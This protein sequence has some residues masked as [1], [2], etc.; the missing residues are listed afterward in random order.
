VRESKG[1]RREQRTLTP[2]WC[3]L[4]WV[5]ASEGRERKKLSSVLRQQIGKGPS[6]AFENLAEISG[7]IPMPNL[8]RDFKC[9]TGHLRRSF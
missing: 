6:N 8:G 1:S 4:F 5:V 3:D 2:F 7:R 9:L